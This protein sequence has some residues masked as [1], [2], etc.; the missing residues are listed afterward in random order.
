MKSL[1]IKGTEYS[2]EIKFDPSTKEFK[3]AGESRPEDAGKLY[4]AILQWL[5]ECFE[6]LKKK[7]NP[8]EIKFEF[9]LVYFNTVSAKYILEI[10]RLLYGLH[11]SGVNVRIA[12]FY[13][14]RD[15]DIKEA[16]EEYAR[17]VNIPFEF[18]CL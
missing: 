4:G 15:E 6:E 1:V 8:E 11:S 7:N 9:A 17:L 14:Q 2:P 16:G 18:V 10:L 12:W 13:K 5:T 3:I